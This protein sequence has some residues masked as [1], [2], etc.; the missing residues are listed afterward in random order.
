MRR[1]DAQSKYEESPKSLLLTLSNMA[2]ATL[3]EIKNN[4]TNLRPERDHQI[5]TNYKY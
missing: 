5:E 4:Y 3:S 2:A 1:K